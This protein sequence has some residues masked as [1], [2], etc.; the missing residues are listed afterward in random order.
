MINLT[1]DNG[2]FARQGWNHIVANRQTGHDFSEFSQ[3]L[4][5]VTGVNVKPDVVEQLKRR[6]NLQLIYRLDVPVASEMII[7]HRP[8]CFARSSR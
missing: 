4:V 6:T 5:S 7:A 3:F 1:C 8:Y 2:G